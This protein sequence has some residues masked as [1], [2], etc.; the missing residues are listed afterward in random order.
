MS[1][2]SR[3]Q[4]E[5]YLKPIDVDCESVIDIGGSQL[6]INKRVRSWNVKEYVIL[7]LETPHEIKSLP[8]V[9][10]NIAWRMP[11]DIAQRLFTKFDVAFVI[12]VMEYVHNPVKAINNVANFLK[13]DGILYISTHEIYPVHKPTEHDCLRYTTNGI[14]KILSDRFEIVECIEKK[15]HSDYFKAG[16]KFEQMKSAGDMI[17]QGCIIKAIKK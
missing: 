4:L 6:P 12:E 10:A 2:F 11:T 13:K 16:F 5:A 14:K 8:D 17:S 3:Q 15:I 1:S 7:D 9:T